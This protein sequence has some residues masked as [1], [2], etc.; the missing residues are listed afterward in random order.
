MGNSVTSI[1]FGICWSDHAKVV[2]HIHQRNASV[3]VFAKGSEM[4]K[5]ALPT[6]T[7]AYNNLEP[8]ASE[9]GAAWPPWILKISAKKVVFLV[10]RGKNQISPLLAP[11]RKTLEKS[12]SAP[13]PWKN[14]S[15]AHAWTLC[16]IQKINNKIREMV[17]SFR[18]LMCNLNNIKKLG[19]QRF[20][21][22]P[23]Q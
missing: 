7:A 2:T 22:L 1:C 10:S 11:P 18:Q 5:I 4:K 21:S 15:D 6:S 23:S 14:Y 16:L 3:H 9:R 13:P 20:S 8:W 12:P 17:L 19:R